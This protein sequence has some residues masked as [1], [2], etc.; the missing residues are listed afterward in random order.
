MNID[1]IT[2]YRT[3]EMLDRMLL[4]ATSTASGKFGL[5]AE[6]DSEGLPKC[7]DTYNRLISQSK[8]DIVCLLHDDIEF[9]SKGWDR[10]ARELF[11]EYKPDI[12]GVVGTTRYLGGKIF[13]SGRP[14][15]VGAY[16][17]DQDGK[18]YVKVF[19]KKYRYLKVAAVDGMIM[20]VDRKYWEKNPFD[21]AFDELFFYDIDFC[22]RA[23]HVAITS[24]ILVKH[25][26]PKSLY[27]KYPEKM[28][29]ITAYSG[30]FNEK[31][32]LAPISIGDQ[33]CA[34]ATLSDF[35]TIGQ[36]ALQLA[37]ESKYGVHA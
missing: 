5:L 8:A 10:E 29:P 21:E 25:S 31:H 20:F 15:T 30:K 23:K 3:K 37:F 7:A 11:V 19:S 1:L 13:S 28:K 27:G 14:N 35:R 26:K 12:L 6:P 18:A 24:S 4:S 22:L 36:N 9:L 32:G 34:M 33:T 2:R 17:C 16:C